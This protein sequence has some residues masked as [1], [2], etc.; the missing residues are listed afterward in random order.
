MQS[1]TNQCNRWVIRHWKFFWPIDYSSITHWSSA[2]ANHQSND[3]PL[4][5]HRLHINVTDFI[6]EICLVMNIVALYSS[7]PVVTSKPRFCF[8]QKSPLCFPYV[9]S[10]WSTQIWRRLSQE[11][12]ARRTSFIKPKQLMVFTVTSSDC[13]G[14]K[15]R[16]YEFLFTLG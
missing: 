5:T 14:K 11:A 7:S 15:A 10:H 16:F 13:K 9:T 1:M 2:I 3:Y 8:S 6:D 4:I 12:F